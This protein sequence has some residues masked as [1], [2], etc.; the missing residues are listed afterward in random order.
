MY[1]PPN[2][3]CDISRPK[4]QEMCPVTRQA[5]DVQLF[6]QS[7]PHVFRIGWRP[8]RINAQSDYRVC[9]PHC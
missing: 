2:I 4:T 5:A 3:I 9:Q 6:G 7:L 8:H 1:P